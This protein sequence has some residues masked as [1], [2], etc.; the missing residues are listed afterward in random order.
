MRVWITKYALTQGVYP[1]E[2]DLSTV[3]DTMVRETKTAYP[4][5]FH[6]PYWH[7]TREEAVK[8]AEDQRVRK[9]AS[10]R[11]QLTRLQKM[12]FEEAADAQS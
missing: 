11:A 2:V 8:Q 3:S 9:I 10:V 4:N 1:A 5:L 6:K 7:T 12:T